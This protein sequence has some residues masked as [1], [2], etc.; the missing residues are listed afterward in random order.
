M[1]VQLDN[2]NVMQGDLIARTNVLEYTT[3]KRLLLVLEFIL[4]PVL[5]SYLFHIKNN[6]S[7]QNVT[8]DWT[9]HLMGLVKKP[10]HVRRSK[11][12]VRHG[13]E[14]ENGDKTAKEND[15]YYNPDHNK[16]Q[17]FVLFTW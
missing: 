17:Q 13:E 5:F 9:Y 1:E 6:Y 2:C 15:D 3:K 12:D 4:N 14:S 16:I 7:T 11:N 8:L 10:I